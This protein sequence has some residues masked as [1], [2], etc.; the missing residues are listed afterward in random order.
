[1]K[2]LIVADGP[3]DDATLPPLIE[4][5]AGR[6]IEPEFE[7]WK[8]LHVRGSGNGYVRKLK[9][10]IGQ[11]LNRGKDGL[12]AVADRDKDRHRQR[13]RDLQQGRDDHRAQHPQYPTV[14]A[15]ADPHV[16]AWLLN[17]PKAV[18]EGIG[19]SSAV[20]IP[21]VLKAGSPKD[22]LDQLIHCHGQS[23]E[24][25]KTVL[26]RIAALIQVERCNHA[27]DTGLADFH[28]EVNAELLTP[29]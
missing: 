19:L 3:R 23:E 4:S 8:D 5:L 9:F 2:L 18:R 13:Q 14:V 20:D 28:N 27:R 10:A 25:S 16:E 21:N 22:A 29:K 6:R 26:G 1:M 7:A 17:D 11:A 12:V 24:N 15:V